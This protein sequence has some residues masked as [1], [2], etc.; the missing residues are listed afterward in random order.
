MSS[1][2][3][4]P[5][6]QTQFITCLVYI[7]YNYIINI[8]NKLSINTSFYKTSLYNLNSSNACVSQSG[9]KIPDNF[10]HQLL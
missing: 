1:E 4:L 9:H 5:L 6:S 2:Y 7:I 8:Y 3:L 10:S